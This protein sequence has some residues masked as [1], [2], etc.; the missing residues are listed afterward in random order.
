MQLLCLKYNHRSCNMTS[1]SGWINYLNSLS[2]YWPQYDFIERNTVVE[3]LFSGH[4]IKRSKQISIRI[5][6]M[7]LR[8]T[9]LLRSHYTVC[10]G[11]YTNKARVPMSFHYIELH[12]RQ[13]SQTLMIFRSINNASQDIASLD[14]IALLVPEVVVTDQQFQKIPC[15]SWASP[16]QKNSRLN[17]DPLMLFCSCCIY[18]QPLHVVKVLQTL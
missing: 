9:F 3:N 18:T 14:N 11:I 13:G 17:D 1:S 8:F 5:Q 10:Q 7:L 6:K 2:F 15:F 12:E 4:D 16:E